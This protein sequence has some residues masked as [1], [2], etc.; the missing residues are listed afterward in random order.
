MTPRERVAAALGFDEAPDRPPA[1]AWGHSYREEWSPQELA[2]VTAD[3]ARRLHYDFVK[4]QPRATCFAEAFGNSYHPANHRLKGPVL[5]TRM[6][7]EVGDWAR[8]SLSNPA[9]LDDQVTAIGLTVEAL[10]EDVP[11]IQTVFSPITVAGYLAGKEP[12]KAVRMLRQNPELVLP[13]LERIADALIDFSKRSVAA[14]AAGVFYAVSGYASPSLVPRA[15]YEK[16]I[17]P[18]DQRITSALPEAAWFNVL[19]LCGDR[20]YLDL[21]Q[22][23]PRIQ[24]A[25]WSVHNRGNPSLREGQELAGRPVMGGLGQRT[26]LV[27]GTPAKVAAEVHSAIEETGGRGVL[28]APGCSVPPRAPEANLKALM[29]A[30]ARVAA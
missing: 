4:F 5:D 12:R 15:V 1:A 9:A 28:V 30:A 26:T 6:V 21:A 22:H 7:S 20:V 13:A 2:R 18:L 10:G 24:T 3:R 17:F 25:S 29:D 14:G 27:S 11:V 8:V 23:L 19:H 16:L